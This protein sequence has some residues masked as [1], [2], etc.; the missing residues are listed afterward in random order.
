MLEGVV[1]KDDSCWRGRHWLRQTESM[2]KGEMRGVVVVGVGKLGVAEVGVG[3]L[4]VA[5]VGG[6]AEV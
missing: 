3:K 1:G 4:G 5:E 2:V 6:G